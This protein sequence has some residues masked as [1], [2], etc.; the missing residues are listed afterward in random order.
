[1]NP[2]DVENLQDFYY[3]CCPECVFRTK[4]ENEFTTHCVNLH[5][6]ALIFFGKMAPETEVKEEPN[7]TTFGIDPVDYVDNDDEDD[8]KYYEEYGDEYEDQPDP[9]EDMKVDDEGNIIRYLDSL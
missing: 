8:K 1:M 4:E 6:N 5:P 7:E 2:W 9:R 3:L